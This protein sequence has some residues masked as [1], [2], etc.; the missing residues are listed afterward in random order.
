[1]LPTLTR[2]S[3]AFCLA[4]ATVLQPLASAQ[5][6]AQTAATPTPPTLTQLHQMIDRGLTSEALTQLDTLAAQS[7]IPPGVTR[8]RGVAL[9]AQGHYPEADT[10]LAAA[11]KQDPHDTEAA[12]MRGLT[13]FRLGKA[14]EAIPLLESAHEWNPQ[15]RVDPSYVLALCYLDTRQYDN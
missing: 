1:M 8:L 12:Q 15:T 4:A 7:P 2:S 10:A 11:L 6:Q 9:Y 14:A 13:L 3:L 5:T